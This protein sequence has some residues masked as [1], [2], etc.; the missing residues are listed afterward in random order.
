MTVATAMSKTLVLDLFYQAVIWSLKTQVAMITMRHSCPQTPYKNSTKSD[1]ID[2]TG[3]VQCDSLDCDGDAAFDGSVTGGNTLTGNG[4]S[5]SS[6]VGQMN[7]RRDGS[8]Q[9]ILK[10]LK[11]GSN[12]SDVTVQFQNDGS[13]TFAG[14]VALNGAATDHPFNVKGLTAFEATNSTNDWIVYTYTDNTFR[15]NYNGSGAD[16]ITIDSDGNVGL[17]ENSPDTKIHVRDSTTGGTG[18]FIQNSNGATNSSA[19]LYFG[20]WS[21]SSTT[22]PQARISAINENVNTAATTLVFWTYTEAV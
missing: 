15:L 19:D 1:G 21:G 22:T 5:I 13:A 7:L 16:E 11:D 4:F 12:T 20:N 10:I 8:T 14:N 9:P 18:I 17:G 6:A 2:V 3:E